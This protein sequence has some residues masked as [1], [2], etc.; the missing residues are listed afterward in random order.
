MALRFIISCLLLGL[1]IFL[2]NTE[3]VDNQLKSRKHPKELFAGRALSD[4]Y[5]QRSFPGNSI[6]MERIT[7]GFAQMTTINFR[8]TAFPGTWTPIGPKNFGGRTLALAFNPQNT[9]TLYAGSASGGL[10]RSYSA[11]LGVQAWQQVSTGFPILGVAAIAINPNDSNEIYIGTGEVYNDLNTGTGFS[12]RVTR[13]TYGIGLLKTT[14]GGVT[15]SKSID[16]A[17]DQLKG[18]QDILI[19]PLRPATI[20][21]ATT[22]GTYRTFNSGQTWSLV[23][24]V[25]MA[26]DLLILPGDTSKVLIAA[27]NS[28]SPN[29]GI[30]RSTNGGTSFV[31]ITAGLPAIYGGKAMLDVCTGSPNVMFASIAEQLTGLGLYRSDDAGINWYQVNTT[32]FQTYQG[33]YAH[34]VLAK[35]SNSDELLTCGVNMWKSYDGGVNLEQ[36]SYWYNWDFNA[37]TVGGV[38]G[39][40]DY[41]HADIHRMYRHPMNEEIVYLATDGGIF[42]SLDGG[43]TFEG[44]NGGYQTQQ[45]YANFSNSHTDSVFAIGGMQDNATAVYEGNAGWRRVIGGD[46]VSTA[47]HTLNDQIVFGSSQYLNIDK[48]T[49]KAVT[50][51]G[52]SL[53]GG[54]YP[55]TNFAGPFAMCEWYP[56][57]MYAGKTKVYV[58]S[59]TGQTW[60]ATNNNLDLDGNPVL[61]LEIA[62]YNYSIVYA[63]TAPAVTNQVG[64]FCT[65]TGGQSWTNVTAGIPNRY[66]MDFAINP[67]FENIVFAAI[68]GFGTPHVF[69]TTNNGA[70]WIAFGTG[71]P[72]V[73]TN[74]LKIDPDNTNI[75]YLGNDLGVY[76]SI[77]AGASWQQFN[78]GLTDATQIMDISISAS[79]RKLRLATHGKGVYERNMLPISITSLPDITTQIE[80]SVFPNPAHETINLSFG[81][82]KINGTIQIVDI[83]GKVVQHFNE[84]VKEINIREL[85]IGIY[86]ISSEIN[87]VKKAVKFLKY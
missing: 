25:R 26:T 71:L 31:K 33:W 77:D 37:T 18:V 85:S 48:S 58:S 29:M 47:I 35:P 86:F 27:G 52:I 80:F 72:D 67:D 83:N 53:N 60:N 62:P 66:V 30:Y 63:A 46:G 20:F 17:Y 38:E 24:N 51:N 61:T 8:T 41:V 68:G 81:D 19:N 54:S 75:M 5:Q 70:S 6:P 65:L 45:F 87:G 49:D 57:Y 23:S 13:G 50:F 59:N 14:N 36:K 11:G 28:S 10:W 21:A 3:N 9:T 64:V 1:I 7:E 84:I 74:T 73:P 2:S 44:C 82:N 56:S 78:E 32:D 16:W 40:P 43:E 4:W 42:R 69:K 22:E 79:N 39:T 12:N 76:V 55:T 34:D 15:W